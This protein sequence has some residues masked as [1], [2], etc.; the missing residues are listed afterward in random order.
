[1]ADWKEHLKLIYFEPRHP[2]T[3][4]GRKKLHKVLK[5]K[6]YIYTV[7]VHRIRHWLQEQEA[8][9]LQKPV[10][11]TFKRNQVITT[12]IDDLWEAD[13]ADVSNLKKDNDDINFLLIAIDVFSRYL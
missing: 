13:L 10:R 7:R 4:A 8:Y 9:S 6:G 12:G 11:R 5:K 3:F 2:A 1:M